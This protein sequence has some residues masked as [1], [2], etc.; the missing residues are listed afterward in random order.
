VSYI[1]RLYNRRHDLGLDS[2]AAATTVDTTT[3]ESSSDKTAVVKVKKP[4]PKWIPTLADVKEFAGAGS[5][6]MMRQVC[7]VGCWTLMA[8]A[9]TRMGIFEIAAHQ[10]ML[11]LWMVIGFV[12]VYIL[13]TVILSC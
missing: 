9:A 1:I 8:S 5:S 12:Q 10:L 4:L 6:L 13:S 7:N 2:A 11:S 3:V